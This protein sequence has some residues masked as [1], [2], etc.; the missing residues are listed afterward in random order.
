MQEDR[1]LG[2]AGLIIAF[3]IFQV[4]RGVLRGAKNGGT[5]MARLNAAAERILK[6]RGASV[7]NPTPRSAAAPK[8]ARPGATRAKSPGTAKP[9][10]HAPL[11]KSTTPAVIRR[12]GL[13]SSGREPVVQR[14]R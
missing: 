12:D 11:P 10:N 9:H 6:E 13:L 14:R 8:A 7:A 5:G 4:V 3:I 2:W 1:W